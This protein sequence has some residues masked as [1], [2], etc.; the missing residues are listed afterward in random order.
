[1]DLSFSRMLALK[2]TGALPPGAVWTADLAVL[3]AASA[4]QQA[5]SPTAQR[6]ASFLRGQDREDDQVQVLARLFGIKAGQNMGGVIDA[7]CLVG[8]FH[9]LLA[10]KL[11]VGKE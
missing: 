11:T 8:S 6:M 5:A 10:Q 7:A 9:P 2:A 3:L 4:A 1:M